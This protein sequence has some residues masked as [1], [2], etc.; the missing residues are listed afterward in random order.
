MTERNFSELKKQ[1]ETNK[2]SN[3]GQRSDRY[4]KK[5]SL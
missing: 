2:V 3:M 4:L 5:I 1:T